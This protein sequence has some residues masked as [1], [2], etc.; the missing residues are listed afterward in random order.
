VAV[1]ALWL[2]KMPAE[3]GAAVQAQLGVG[4]ARR[5]Q[6]ALVGQF[7][8][9]FAIFAL[10]T[11]FGPIGAAA[12]LSEADIGSAAS[13]GLMGGLPGAL[14]ASAFGARLGRVPMIVAGSALV[15]APVL[16]M[17]H[18]VSTLTGFATALFVLNVGWVLALSYYMAEASAND[19]QG[20]LTQWI[21]VSQIAGSAVAPALVGSLMGERLDIA[22]MASAVAVS[23]GAVFCVVA[24]LGALRRFS[25]PGGGT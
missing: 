7:K 22:F 25:F 19:P 6:A 13:I 17:A 20:R 2:R 11:F 23:L 10:W 14:V 12:G 15:L 4:E 9:Q 24:S 5:G 18:G 16:Y 8:L 21:G 1:A 3:V